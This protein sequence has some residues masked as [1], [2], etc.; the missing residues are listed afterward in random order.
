MI[1]ET[2]STNVAVRCY[3]CKRE[4]PEEEFVK[5]S[6]TTS[7]RVCKACQRKRS[8]EDYWKNPKKVNAAHREYYRTH[9]TQVR[10]AQA[11]YEKTAKGHFTKRKAHLK[12]SFGI[13]PADY[14]SMLIDHDGECQ[15]CRQPHTPSNLLCV[16]HDH[17]TD[18]VRGLLCDHCN[19]ALGFVEE[20]KQILSAMAAYI[21]R[22][23]VVSEQFAT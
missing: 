5:K 11:A 6:N 19:S 4:G 9:T 13:T 23:N 15:I 2:E 17:E 18:Q 14:L 16:D 20:D 7:S 12:R 21:D 22:H 3:Q 10:A 8:K 1:V